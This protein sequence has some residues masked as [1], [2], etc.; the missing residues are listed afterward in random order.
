MV[1]RPLAARRLA[2]VGLV[3]ADH[4]WAGGPLGTTSA[5]PWSPH[6]EIASLPETEPLHLKTSKVLR[7]RD[8]RPSHRRSCIA[9]FRAF[10]LAVNMFAQFSMI[11]PE[12][13]A[14][15][16]LTILAVFS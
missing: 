14:A 3:V 8:L 5:P 2:A 9:F 7:V 16:A 13:S 10:F 6:G 15:L 4:A 1:P 11:L 12:H